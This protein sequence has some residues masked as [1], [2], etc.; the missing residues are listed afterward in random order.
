MLICR[1]L[2]IWSVPRIVRR[3]TSPGPLAM[4]IPDQNETSSKTKQGLGYAIWQT[5]LGRE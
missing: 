2:D 4:V 5:Q 3:I 1:V